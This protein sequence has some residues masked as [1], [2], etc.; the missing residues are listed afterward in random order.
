MVGMD[1]KSLRGGRLIVFEGIDGSG[2]TTQLELARKGLVEQGWPLSTSRNLGGTPIGEK[3]RGVIKSPLPRPEMANLY[4][5]AAIQEALI[6][7][8]STER[9]Q[10]KLVL[11]DR[12]PISL[13]AYEI[14]G[15]GLDDET[16]WRHVD[17]G[18]AR[19]KPDL[20]LIYRSDVPTALDRIKH[21]GQ[22]DYFESKSAD[23]F[24]RVAEGYQAAAE[25]YPEVSRV[26]DA[27]RSIDEIHRDT[28]ALIR[29]VLQP[30]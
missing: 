7:A 3:L 23:Y 13:A 21:A 9:N 10:G 18:M 28:M 12:G 24:E 1:T 15:G 25:R 20:V 14:Y 19:L 4:I 11:M 5:S 22:A 8:I 26:I 29:Q 2:K 6:E 27:D 16:T 17:D 30:S